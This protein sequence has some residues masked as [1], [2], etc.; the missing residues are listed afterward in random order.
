MSHKI[1][2]NELCFILDRVEGTKAVLLYEGQELIVPRRMLDRE[3][4]EGDAIF[5]ELVCEK[6]MVMRR[7]NLAKAI[8]KEILEGD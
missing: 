1:N 8:L 6:K 5:T 3:V 2:S 7:E 4:Q